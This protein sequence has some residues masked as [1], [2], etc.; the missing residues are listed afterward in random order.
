MDTELIIECEDPATKIVCVDRDGWFSLE[1]ANVERIDRM[2]EKQDEH[3]QY[4]ALW[5]ST[6]LGSGYVSI[7]GDRH[8]MAAIAY[9]IKHRLDDECKRCA[10]AWCSDGVLLWSPRNSNGKR[11]LITR[12]QADALAADIRGK[13]E[14]A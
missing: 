3:G 4:R 10:V 14:T 2:D 9:A 6:R 13:L 8:D 11:V 7:E 1:K 5:L 12:Q